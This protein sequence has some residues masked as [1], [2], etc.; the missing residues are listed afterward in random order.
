MT[1][2]TQDNGQNWHKPTGQVIKLINT[3]TL[4]LMVII[5]EAQNNNGICLLLIVYLIKLSSS[6][7]I[8]LNDRVRRHVDKRSH[9]LI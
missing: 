5:W 1:N 3:C 7:T 9:G 2:A 6:H 4:K 8:T